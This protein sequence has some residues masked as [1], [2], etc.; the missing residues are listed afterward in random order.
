M[1]RW[2]SILFLFALA[3]IAA[4]PFLSTAQYFYSDDGL[5]HLFR[6]FALDQTIHQGVAYPRW[7]FD[8]AYGY[9]YPIFDFYPPLAAYVAETL[10]LLGS[11]FADAIKGT[12][13]TCIVVAIAGAYAMGAELFGNEKDAKAIGLL[14]AAAYVFFPYFLV[15]VYARGAI[16][17]ALGAAILPWLIWSL[18]R[19]LRQR[20]ITSALLVGFASALLL[21]AHSLT[22]FL[23]AP[24][25][26]GYLL[27]E[28][29]QL[30]AARRPAALARLTLSAILGAGLS[31]IYWLPFGAEL[32]FTRMGSGIEFITAV[33]R[34]HFLA[35]SDLVQSSLLYRYG[36]APF[37]LGLVPVILG[38][39]ALVIV[40]I[41]GRKFDQ[42]IVVLFFGAVSVLGAVAM[43]VP[44]RRAWLAVPFS[45][46]IQFPWRVSILIGLGFSITV[47]ALPLVLSRLGGAESIESRLP[48]LARQPLDLLR[49]A[50]IAAVACAIIW[51]ATGN[52]APQE[53]FFPRGEVNLAQ[54]ARFEAYSG[55]VGTTTW[56]EYL[57]ATV[58]VPNLLTYRA[59]KEQPTRD[60]V[61]VQIER[62]TGTQRVFLVS[63]S[64]P[65]SMTLR[66]FY[67]PGWQA[68]L[69]GAS[70]NA[71]ASAPA[72]LLAVQVPAGE[73]SVAVSLDDTLP[74]QAGTVISIVSAL[75]F[76][77][78]T[79]S[80]FRRREKE[81][82]AVGIVFAIALAAFL[83]P[84]SAAIAAPPAA[85][86][87]RQV[88]VSPE[89]DL[90]GIAVDG[91]RLDS[92]A[93][94][95]SD[96]SATLH[97][98]VYW[99]V[100]QSTDEKVFSWRLVDSAGNVL[101]Q[102][103]QLSRY[104]TGNAGAWIPNEITEDY[105][106]LPL[107]PG[108]PPGR[109]VIQVAYSGEYA[110]VGSID[111]ARGSSPAPAP[112]AIEHQVVAQVGNQIRLVGYDAPQTA[113]PGTRLA[114][115]LY[116]KAEQNV[117]NDYTGFVQLLDIDGNVAAR[118]QH[119][120]IPGGGLSPT[121]LWV[122][123]ELVADRDGFDLPRDLQ[124]GLYRLIAGL[125]SNP[126][127]ARLPVVTEAGP[128]PDDV[129]VLG[130]VKVP[131]EVQNVT[132]AHTSDVSL[133]PAILL[134]GY[135]LQ[136][137]PQQI[138]LKLY[139]RARAKIESDYKVFVH[140]VNEQGQ[141]VV[142]E[143]QLPD[144]GRYPTRIWDAGEQIID[145]YP[146]SIAAL[147]SGHYRIFA[148][149]YS[150]ESGERLNAVD[151]NG[152]ALTDRQ[153]EI[154]AFDVSGR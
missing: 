81:A 102:R 94:Q 15:D 145:S 134:N 57:P 75:V 129:V 31:A 83:I 127:L 44:M 118:P 53:L 130:D 33:F 120:T 121:S 106:D 18:R 126:D 78:L 49:L 43:I 6:L 63:S 74:Q 153:I 66:S 16:A 91:A 147:P 151:K 38:T 68:T 89:L 138:A 51:T 95:V 123:G 92:N 72:G 90:I 146:F 14:T 116:W 139:W 111:L 67:F 148:G 76:A 82:I 88:A 140:I 135:D 62:W 104:G 48:H 25:L 9:G 98:R 39:L 152:N 50:A 80:A 115:T 105:F 54:L 85:L 1:R 143:D 65:T 69:D 2:L 109:Y 108:I 96:P 112:I 64:Q 59:T 23:V 27:L 45:T 103:E 58:K 11:G 87:T 36:N 154:A 70:T 141:I 35:P 117:N 29:F 52:L 8:L 55:F 20:T 22:L 86:Q 137:Q 150:P 7:V 142:Q 34:Y 113:R 136:V 30:P 60:T 79:L 12:F 17:E 97:L 100:K 19:G 84:A 21:L 42:R 93:W 5:D 110:T 124:P 26:L 46:M 99:F 71:F 56:G 4:R 107:H 32:K 77:G 132:P 128:E 40:G 144:A 101:S 73:H 10:H 122:P 131:M 125:Y 61:E 149:M 114:L 13:V 24:V 37:A 133:G 41:A 3:I 47:S 28:L 119:D